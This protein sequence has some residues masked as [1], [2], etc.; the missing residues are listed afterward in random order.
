MLHALSPSS[1]WSL[2]ALYTFT[3]IF[4]LT[5]SN[6][7]RGLKKKK[8]EKCWA[9]THATVQISRF[10]IP[11]LA[12]RD[13]IKNNQNKSKITVNRRTR[14]HIYTSVVTQ[15]PFGVQHRDWLIGKRS[16]SPPRRLKTNIWRC[17]QSVFFGRDETWL[18][19]RDRPTNEKLPRHVGTVKRW[20]TLSLYAL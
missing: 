6:L 16:S 14:N 4:L 20:H 18:H 11:H 2:H 8:K 7:T 15:R 13:Q 3:N 10:Q 1:S 19:L 5:Y 12:M 9:H 17:T